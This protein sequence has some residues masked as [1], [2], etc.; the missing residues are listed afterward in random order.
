MLEGRMFAHGRNRT[1]SQ[2]K[3]D[4]LEKYL[5]PLMETIRRYRDTILLFGSNRR[6]S[7]GELR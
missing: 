3:D 6:R 4:E 1:S 7:R 5:H 2:R